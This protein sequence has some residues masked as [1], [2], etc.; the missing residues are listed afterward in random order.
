MAASPSRRRA[1]GDRALRNTSD[2]RGMMDA[3]L[4]ATRQARYSA[5]GLGAY[6]RAVGVDQ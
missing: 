6:T 4:W 3:A 1:E 5:P 2:Q